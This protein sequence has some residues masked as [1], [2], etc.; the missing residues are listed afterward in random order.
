MEELQMAITFYRTPTG[1][2]LSAIAAD[3]IP[4]AAKAQTEWLSAA[5]LKATNEV[6]VKATK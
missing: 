5:A 1:K 3:V 6:N 2:K 4:D